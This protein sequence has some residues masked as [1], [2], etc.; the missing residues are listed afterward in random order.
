[1]Q[2]QTSSDLLGRIYADL[3]DEKGDHIGAPALFP[4]STALV[5]GPGFKKQYTP[6]YPTNPDAVLREDDWE[7]RTFRE[8]DIKKEGGELKIGRFWAYDYFGDGS[9]YLL[10]TPGHTV[11]HLCGLARVTSIPDSFVLMGGDA[12]HQ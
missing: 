8:V 3:F 6:G 11:G 9:F 4:K 12:C 10:A 7:G 1:M 5:V 2:S